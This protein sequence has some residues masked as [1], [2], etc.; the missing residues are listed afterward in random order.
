MSNEGQNP[1]QYR[2]AARNASCPHTVRWM[3]MT[4][5]RADL[6]SGGGRDH[7]AVRYSRVKFS[8]AASALARGFSFL[9]SLMLIALA[10]RYLEPDRLGLWLT[11]IGL[12][13][14]LSVVDLGVG[15]GLINAVAESDGRD[16]PEVAAID[17]GTAFFSLC[18][19]AILLGFS[20]AILY[21]FVDWGGLLNVRSEAARDESGPAV[22]ILMVS[23]LLALPLG[24]S[25]K[26]NLGYQE[27]FVASLWT[28]AGSL[29]S[30]VAGI[31]AAEQRAGVA[32][33]TGAVVG[34]HVLGLGLNSI[35][36]YV[37]QKPHLKPRLANVR[38]E[39]AR[40]LLS[41]G[42]LYFALALAGAIGLHADNLVIARILGTDAVP[43][44]AIPL[45]VF[46]VIPTVLSFALAPLWPA[47]AESVAR[48]DTEW[49]RRTFKRSLQLSTAVAVPSS[50][51][52]VVSA[53]F[54]I[55]AWAGK[56]FAPSLLVLVGF[57]LWATLTAI[58][59]PLAM[60][61]NGLRVIGFQVVASL[62]MALM[63]IT[64]SILLVSRIGVAGAI[65]GTVISLVFCIVLPSSF[66]VAKVLDGM[67][68]PP[69]APND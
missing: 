42:R 18:G 30:L 55:Q 59:G 15:N 63:N 3:A 45:R 14:V 8:A 20:F 68:R 65:Y 33:L 39:S 66:Y 56:Q 25:Q 23:V 31:L 69:S 27:G 50:M 22:I 34:G 57:G 6:P 67:A 49:V 4:R 60:L 17:V 35:A 37:F 62:S 41:L 46:M 44:Y 7:W 52:L 19:I 53:G 32:A 43:S 1:P 54:L 12:H 61:L 24:V 2:G 29:A 58:T 47:Y 9:A 40:R 26:V 38:R 11:I 21:S 51:I 5:G 64:L 10:S 48:G 16:Q 28:C 13:L 36:V